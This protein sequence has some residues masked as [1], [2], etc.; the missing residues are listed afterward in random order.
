MFL[1]GIM[2]I[3]YPVSKKV[4]LTVS[5]CHIPYEHPDCFAFLAA[6]KK[7]LKPD[8]VISMGDLADFHDI[9]FHDSDPELMSAGDEL[10]ALQKKAKMLEKIFPEMYIIGSNHGDLPA[11]RAFASKMPRSFLR[12]YNE[13][14]GVGK[15][16]KFVD[17]LYLE[18]D[19]KLYYFTHGISKNGA[20]LAAQR[21]VCVVS[22]HFHTEFRIDYVSNPRDLLW[23]L[24][25]G[26]LID[27][28]SLAFAYDRL[29]LSRPIIGTGSISRGFPQLHPMVLGADS[30]WIKKVV[31]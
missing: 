3:K 7:H 22:G 1:G 17:E 25:T 28:K 6:L 10:K 14:Y 16:W 20:K 2:K 8:L 26:C 13:I 18:D 30:R 19:K 29:N 12:P 9:S 21:G 23:S 15:G 5:D 31:P 4:I 27:P 24:Q 11:R